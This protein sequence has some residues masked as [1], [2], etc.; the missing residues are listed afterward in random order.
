MSHDR[1]LT[2]ALARKIVFVSFLLSQGDPSF[3][4]RLFKY[5]ASVQ[6]D[7]RL[8][9]CALAEL[10]AQVIAACRTFVSN[11]WHVRETAATEMSLVEQE[12]C[13]A[14]LSLQSALEHW[15]D[16][17]PADLL[18][19][20]MADLIYR[21]YCFLCVRGGRP[22]GGAASGQ[23]TP[24]ARHFSH[25]CQYGLLRLPVG[26][27]EFDRLFEEIR[28]AVREHS[29]VFHQ[30]LARPEARFRLGAVVAVHNRHYPLTPIPDAIL[31]EANHV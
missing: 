13:E 20:L 5:V 8:E 31:T 28:L 25:F 26:L 9:Q 15:L 14:V 1:S 23:A 7:W 10:T 12:A 21:D 17:E 27:P 18:C 30:V 6:P 11:G 4:G 22:R 24:R 3:Q 2:V 16:D 29:A 19:E